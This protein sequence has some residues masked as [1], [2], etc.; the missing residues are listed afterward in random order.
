MKIAVAESCPFWLMFLMHRDSH[1]SSL[2][3]DV[4]V[5]EEDE[6]RCS[7]EAQRTTKQSQTDAEVQ[8]GPEVVHRLQET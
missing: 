1:F 3:L 8:G 7:N 6:L 5:Y 2:S 4:A